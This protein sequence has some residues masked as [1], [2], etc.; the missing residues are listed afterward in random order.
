[1]TNT[2]PPFSGDTP[3]CAKCGHK[4]ASTRFRSARPR[5]IWHDWNDATIM[6]GPLPERLE[7]ECDRCEFQWDEALNQ[8]PSA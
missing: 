8:P 3:T 6:R 2:L 7:R 1:V 5:A 4:E